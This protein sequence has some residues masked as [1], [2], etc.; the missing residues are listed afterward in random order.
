[1]NIMEIEKQIIRQLHELPMESVEEVLEF[2]G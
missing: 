1:M 2:A